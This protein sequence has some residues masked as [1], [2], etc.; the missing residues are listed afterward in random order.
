[1]KIVYI[2]HAVSG[3]L[4]LGTD[5]DKIAAIVREINLNYPDVVPVVPYYL[6]CLV[7]DYTRE[8]ELMRIRKNARAIL[9]R[10]AIDEFWQCG[11]WLT[12]DM[13][14]WEAMALRLGIPVKRMFKKGLHQ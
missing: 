12:A 13:I 8:N 2:S 6:D 3:D 10:G 5:K 14:A 11:K 4:A 1:M 9:E 7:L